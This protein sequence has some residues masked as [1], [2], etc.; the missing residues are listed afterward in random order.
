MD[1]PH[2]W[3]DAMLE[4][5]EAEH[6]GGFRLRLRFSSGETGVVDLSKGRSAGSGIR[7]A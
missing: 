5:I 1:D 2:G 6:V 7:A 3:S 4:I